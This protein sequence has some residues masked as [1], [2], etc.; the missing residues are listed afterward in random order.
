[1]CGKHPRN[2]LQYLPPSLP[3]ANASG[4]MIRCYFW[5]IKWELRLAGCSMRKKVTKGRF[6]KVFPSRKSS[7]QY[8]STCTVGLHVSDA[9]EY[10]SQ[11]CSDRREL[12]SCKS[13]IRLLNSNT[14]IDFCTS[15]FTAPLLP[16]RSGMV[17]IWQWHCSYSAQNISDGA[18][19]DRTRYWMINDASF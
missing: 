2:R 17:S 6:K 5:R 7:R 19:V 12:R 3:V 18:S 13:Y 4:I 9:L 10:R 11:V 1:M 8:R 16:L 14:Q 15:P